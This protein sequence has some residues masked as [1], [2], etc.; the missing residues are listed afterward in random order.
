MVDIEV[1]VKSGGKLVVCD[2]EKV[3]IFFII[4]EKWK[5]YLCLMDELKEFV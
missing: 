1:V 3:V 2:I 4:D 5:E